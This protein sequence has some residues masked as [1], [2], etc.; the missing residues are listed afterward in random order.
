MSFNFDKPIQR[1]GT[2]C[3][4]WD[5]LKVAFGDSELLPL[6]IA[7]MDFEV[8]EE[9]SQAV[10][11]RALHPIYGYATPSKTYQRTFIQWVEQKYNCQLSEE[12]V[13]HSPGVVSAVAGAVMAFTSP[14]DGIVIFPPVYHPFRITIENQG[15]KVLN[16][17]M[18]EENGQ[19]RLDLER[20]SQ[21]APQAKMVILC[22]PHNPTG[23]VFTHQELTKIEAIAKANNLLV[24]S[25]EIHSD[26]VYWGLRHIPFFTLSDWAKNNSLCLMAPS[27]TFNIAGLATSTIL[28]FNEK[29]RYHWNRIMGD[30]LHLAGGNV[31]GLVAC[32]AAYKHGKPW[33][34]ALISY[35]EQNVLFVEQELARLSRPIKLV[36]PEGTYVP[37]VDFRCLNLSNQQLTDFL[38]QKCNLAMND[39]YTFGVGGDG[40]ARLNIAT[41]RANLAQF[42]R[43]L[44]RGLATL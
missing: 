36:H 19:F 7:D 28:I 29:L 39:G 4:K 27:K 31:F 17:P 42:I 1:R 13:C 22:N 34:E 10:Q 9:V 38:R 25:D 21:L 12:A 2:N 41:Q 18:I 8:P 35:L 14:G 20:F 33:L 11:Q 40:F 3:A 43:Q 6:W 37:L 5:K 30:G 44:E 32:E 15:R 24:V 16:C 26:I 23:R